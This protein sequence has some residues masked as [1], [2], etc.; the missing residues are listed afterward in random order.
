M[1][2]A[3]TLPTNLTTAQVIDL[4]FRDP[5]AKYGLEEFRD[6]GK[7]PEDVLTIYPKTVES[8]RAKGEVRYYLKCLQRCGDIQVYSEK[9]ASPEEIVRQLWIYKL[10]HYYGYPLDHIVIEYQVDFG[11]V[12]A[13]KAADILVFQ[14]DGKTA[15]IIVEV[16]RPDRKDGLNQLKSYLNAE[17]SPVGVWSNGLERVIL[18]RPYPREFEDTL[19]EIPTFQQEPKDVLDAKLTLGHLKREFDFKRIIQNLEELVLANAGV[20][21]FNEIFKIIFAKLYDEKAA[22]D[23]KNNEVA[24]RK[25][26]DPQITYE[27]VNKLFRRAMEEWPGIFDENEQIKLTPHHL[28][29]VIGPLERIRLLGA[30]MRVM[31][32]AFEYLMPSV[33]K[34][35]N[36]QFFTPRYVIDMCVKM[37]N[38]TK[39]EYVLDPA[40]GSAGF[41]IHV[42]EQV[43][44]IREEKNADAKREDRK[45]TYAAKYLWGVDFDE[46]SAKVARAL[47]LIAG[48]GRSHVFRVNSLDPREWF[49]SQEGEAIRNS[50]RDQNLLTNRPQGNKVI[51]DVEAWDYYRDMK[52]DV[53]LTNPPFAGEIRDKDLLRRYALAG[54]AIARK[55]KKGPKEERDVLFIER[56]LQLL[57][58]GGRLAIVL[59]QGK[60]NNASLAY[61][62]EWVLRR[63]RLLAV[64]GLHLNTFKP[65]TGTKTSVLFVQKYTDEQ[66]QQIK[67][68]EDSIKA[69]APDYAQTI[70]KLLK[71][72]ASKEDIEEDSLPDEISE[73][74]HELFDEPEPEDPE[75]EVSDSQA[76]GEL[77][78]EPDI[79]TLEQELKSARTI[80]TD[81]KIQVDNAREANEKSEQ[82]RLRGLLRSAERRLTETEM[83]MS[84]ADAKEKVKSVRGRLELLMNDSKALGSLR[85]KWV[86]IKIA[87][88]LDYPV[89]MA[90]SEVGGKDSSGE[91]EFRKHDGNLIED[92]FGN[93][94]IK[95][96]C[97][98][99]REDDPPGI[100]ECFTA[101]AQKRKLSFWR[102]D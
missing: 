16:K 86:D 11:T 41:L 23:R 31:D 59:P 68:V 20:D 71:R 37:L 85:E 75:D 24:F 49:T 28:Q 6:L 46:R 65:H 72:H 94:L 55:S 102:E 69:E 29:V 60:F 78:E 12:T 39:K 38:P 100:A 83:A 25:S 48:D 43:W 99:Y 89:F 36:G 77:A 51:R 74:L 42:M 19:T 7:K 97:V 1:P 18:Y 52:F 15:K 93:P 90:T 50:L 44:P 45:H 53:I 92:E 10:H 27:T 62:R 88:K 35:K 80:V 9:K 47:M 14:K 91:Y 13:E 82:K 17:G 3:D 96:D 64:V 101:W 61:I 67:A 98:A 87:Q 34:K 73:A 21:E 79:E 26:D 76:A 81:L 70:A 95:Q 40:C 58:P 8:G 66:M 5:A 2:V 63:A 4:I 33:A 84:E 56:C 22:K 32:D 30:N 54:P 57:K